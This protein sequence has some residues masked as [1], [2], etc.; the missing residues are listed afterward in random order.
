VIRFPGTYGTVVVVE[1]DG[2]TDEVVVTDVDGGGVGVVDV[3]GVVLGVADVGVGVGV[4]LLDVLERADG[5]DGAV[6][7]GAPRAR[8]GHLVRKLLPAVPV[9]D[10]RLS[11]AATSG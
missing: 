1:V 7:A 5:V 10:G 6:V 11:E 8:A 9:A 3:E 4:L 2:V